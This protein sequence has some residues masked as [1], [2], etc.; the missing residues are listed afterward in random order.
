MPMKVSPKEVTIRELTKG[1]IDKEND[2][3]FGYGGKLDIRPPYQREFVYNK[4]ETEAVIQSI[5]DEMPLN[6]MYWVIKKNKYEI[7]D[8]QQRTIS[9]CKFVID[10]FSIQHKGYPSGFDHLDDDVQEKFLDY[11]LSV[12][13]CTGSDSERLKWFKIVN[14]AGKKLEN[15]ELL[16]AVYTGPWVD[17]ARKIFSKKDCV[18]YQLSHEY[19]KLK[20]N[21]QQYLERAIKWH[22]QDGNIKEYM[23]IHQNDPTA[24]E[25]W[26]YYKKMIEWVKTTFTV[27]RDKPMQGVTN[28]GEL[29]NK[30]EDMDKSLDPEETEKRIQELIE[31]PEVTSHPGIYEYILSGKEK[32]LNIRIFDNRD[33]Q[34]AYEKQKGLCAICGK[35]F[36]IGDMEGDHKKPWS[37]GGHTTEKNCQMLCKPCNIEKSAK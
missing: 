37:K 6:T 13:E 14:I 4:N 24:D 30:Y 3:V 29:Y 33:K 34:K 11:K 5:L 19:I 26:E 2:G 16:N 23:R 1:Y 8:G 27:V 21:R 31:D 10:G 7:L 18:A 17:D 22:S 36:K 20:P 15:Q 28:W 9:I 35:L 12:Y 32:H 25:L